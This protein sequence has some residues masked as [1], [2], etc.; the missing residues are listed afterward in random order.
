MHTWNSGP[1]LYCTGN[2]GRHNICRKRMMETFDSLGAI[3]PAIKRLRLWTKGQM[4]WLKVL[5]FTSSMTEEKHWRFFFPICLY[6]LRV[7]P[8]ICATPGEPLLQIMLGEP[9]DL[10]Q[11]G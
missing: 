1:V 7:C 6:V 3:G 9:V 10:T 8:W 11:G 2:M 5:R 4:I